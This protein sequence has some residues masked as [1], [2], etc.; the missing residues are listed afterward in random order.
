[1]DVRTF[2][3]SA[4]VALAMIGAALPVRAAQAGDIADKASQAEALL[5]AGKPQEAL[6][7][8]D[9]ASGDFWQALPLSV[10]VA[11]FVDSVDGYGNYHALPEASFK[12]GDTLKIY[13]E[14]V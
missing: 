5:S 13:L 7:A 12:P 2:R 9:A 4:F 8:F 10:R 6:A 1:M 11:T 3:R 14:P